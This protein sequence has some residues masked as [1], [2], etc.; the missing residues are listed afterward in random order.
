V[1]RRDRAELAALLHALHVYGEPCGWC[2][3]S[4]PEPAGEGGAL[5]CA[6]SAVADAGNG[7]PL[8]WV[9]GGSGTGRPKPSADAVAG[10]D[11]VTTA[12]LLCSRCGW[13]ITASR[14][15]G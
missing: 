3:E 2:G 5:S 9:S 15:T 11:W 7:R 8:T 4:A 1:R 13:E 14:Q 12:A 6:P 10:D